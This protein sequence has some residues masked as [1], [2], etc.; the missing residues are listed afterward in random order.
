MKKLVL[1]LC[2]LL[3]ISSSTLCYGVSLI[4]VYDEDSIKVILDQKKLNFD[5][6]PVIHNGRTLVPLRA[7]FEAFGADVGWD[8]VTKTVTAIKD[9]IKIVLQIGN[10]EATVND[11]P[12]KLDVPSKIVNGRTLVPVRF[13]SESLGT[14]VAWDGE[15]KT[16]TI[17]SLYE[18]VEV[19]DGDTLSIDYNGKTEKI[20][21]IGVNCPES[22]HPTKGVEPFGKEASNF[23]KSSLEGKKISFELDVEER[24]QYGR[25]LAY[26]YLDFKMFN[27][28]LLEEGYAQVMTVQ[29]NSKYADEYVE[30]QKS[31]REQNKG[32]WAL[33]YYN[34]E[35]T[36]ERININTASYE[37]LIKIIH[38]DEDRANQIIQLRPFDTVDDLVRVKGI[39]ESRLADIK[40]EGKAYVD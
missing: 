9:D 28:T 10:L 11:L 2:V 39:G 29:P 19:I 27:K 14:I 3:I 12:I 26:V 21:L 5:Q 31:A 15:T 4:P 8:Q 18:V 35:N 23:T 20:R 30:I 24:D 33:D 6:P 16:V 7:I 34:K 32:L 13:I 38:I 40:A 1:L 36:I 17:R 37:D 25:I 22:V